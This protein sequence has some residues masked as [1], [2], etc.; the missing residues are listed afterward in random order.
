MDGTW[1]DLPQSLAGCCTCAA[2]PLE[3]RVM[4]MMMTM[5]VCISSSNCL[6]PTLCGLCFYILLE[7]AQRAHHPWLLAVHDVLGL[8]LV[9]AWK[10]GVHSNSGA[11]TPDLSR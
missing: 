8:G 5:V 3:T 4:M 6:L 11:D 1:V 2:N 9:T 10:A 7:V